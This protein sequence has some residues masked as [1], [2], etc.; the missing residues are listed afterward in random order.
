M[1]STCIIYSCDRRKRETCMLTTMEALLQDARELLGYGQ[2][3][4]L[5]VVLEREGARIT[6]EDVL[7]GI[8][9]KR[10]V[11]ELMILNL[12]RQ[13]SWAP[14][15]VPSKL[16]SPNIQTISINQSQNIQIGDSNRL[17]QVDNK[18][19]E[20]DLQV[21]MSVQENTED[22]SVIPDALHRLYSAIARPKLWYKL[23]RIARQVDRN[24]VL[25]YRDENG[26]NVLHT[27]AFHNNEDAVMT[28]FRHFDWATLSTQVTSGT[29]PG[30]L[31]G[32]TAKDI[33]V[34]RHN[35]SVA[36]R[37]DS[38]D[39]TDS[40]MNVIHK[41]VRSRNIDKLKEFCTSD[42]NLVNITDS[43]NFTPLHYAAGVGFLDG[44]KLL[45]KMG[46]DLNAVTESGE[47]ALGRAC[48]MGYDDVVEY[49][50]DLPNVDINKSLHSA[51]G[52]VTCLDAAV[53]GNFRD[54]YNR[55][56]RHG[57]PVTSN[58]LVCAARGGHVELVKGIAAMDGID[59]NH[60]NKYGNT[61]LHLASRDGHVDVVRYLINEDR[62]DACIQN[63]VGDKTLSEASRNGNGDVVD[64]HK[65][66][67]TILNNKGEN[68]A[69]MAA[70]SGQVQ[71]LDAILRTHPELMNK[72][73][74][75][76]EGSLVYLVRGNDK[77]RP[78]WHYV[79]VKR[80][81]LADFLV[82]IKGKMIELEDYGKV[83]SSGW[84]EDPP[85]DIRQKVNDKYNT[86]KDSSHEDLTPLHHAVLEQYPSV[87]EKLLELGAA[88][89]VRDA[90]KLTP[91]HLACMRGNREIVK[92]LVEAGADTKAADDD[93][94]TSLNV[95][96]LNHQDLIVAFLE[97][98]E[99]VKF[100]R[101]SIQQPVKDI[102][103]LLEHGLDTDVTADVL[104]TQLHD[105][106]QRLMTGGFSCLAKLNPEEDSSKRFEKKTNTNKTD[107]EE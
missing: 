101:D 94:D 57:L 61:A 51:M 3:D 90:Y 10:D 66:D 23:D 20:D 1:D 8:A 22:I 82:K 93:G 67:P 88:T 42:H 33:A 6:K 54:I 5:S 40:G 106:I 64:E 47:T 44:V 45:L 95:A 71:C 98:V 96:K 97:K 107:E 77:E 14:E 50:T 85:D 29:H 32:C 60:Q 4:Q 25:E 27:A 63:N 81:L 21:E 83:L 30:E 48:R 68:P 73:G 89:D 26:F 76:N 92:L 74:N 59:V 58:T 105:I 65:R 103:E 17:L 13:E 39:K 35:K 24:K 18:R 12:T 53:E 69:H 79:L 34:K 78:A 43:D 55:L 31:E 62:A 80:K 2:D 16:T 87:V 49:L 15:E 100:V 38:L 56:Q 52:D 9:K 99:I 19:D 102:M 104:K 75:L 72:R 36:D 7:H 28:I 41:V 70:S 91:L 37:I 86:C 46:A 84:G 11:L